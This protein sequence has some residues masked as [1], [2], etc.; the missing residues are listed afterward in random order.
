MWFASYQLD[1]CTSYL[2]C[3]I[4]GPLVSDRQVQLCT[5]V[6]LIFLPFIFDLSSLRSFISCCD[7]TISSLP[8]SIPLSAASMTQIL[9]LMVQVTTAT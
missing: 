2:Q 4:A 6:A 9:L 5:K 3:Q 8:T 1:V 7:Y